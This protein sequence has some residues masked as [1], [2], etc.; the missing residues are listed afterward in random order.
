MNE[1][2]IDT[3]PPDPM[4]IPVLLAEAATR[5]PDACAL[6][7][8]GREPLCYGRLFA[9][10]QSAIDVLNGAGIGP[11]DRVALVLPN[12]PEMVVA[13]LGISACASCA[14]LNPAYREAEFRFYLDDLQAKA[15]VLP[16]HGMPEARAAAAASGVPVIELDPKPDAEAGALTLHAPTTGKPRGRATAC[17]EDVALVLH[18]SGTTSRPKIVPLTQL[19]LRLS[20]TNV[21]SS[22][23]LT[24]SDR[25]LNIMPLFHIHGL[26][27][28]L[29]ASLDA[30]ASVA[31]VPPFSADH[32]FG[33]LDA[34][35]PTW[36]SAVPPMHQAILARADT[37]TETIARRPLRFIRS[38]SSAL[39]PQ[40]MER[41]EQ[42]FGVPVIEA[43]GMTEAA[44]QMTSNPLPPRRRKPRSVGLPAGPEIAIMD[45][46]GKLLGPERSGEV[47]I[48]GPTVTHG[49]ENNPAANA[50]AFRN[51]W[52]R[53]G[54]LGELD[55]D[56]YLFLTGR[57][58]ELI[59]RGGEKVSPR[60]VDE[61]LMDH[62]DVIQAVAFGVPHATLGED[63]AAAVVLRP[64]SQVTPQEL[65]EL[66]FERLAD[67]KVPSRIVVLDEIPKGATGKLQRIGLAEKLASRLEE[68]FVAPR[69][70]LETLVAQMIEEVLRRDRVGI[71]DNF[72]AIG[73]DSLSGTRLMARIRAALGV[74]LPIVTL[75]RKP[76]VEE[77]AAELGKHVDDTQSAELLALLEE[78]EALSDEE[79]AAL[80]ALETDRDAA[81]RQGGE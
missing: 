48:R 34:L 63:L 36:F 54:D 3:L 59:N 44:H 5:H 14:P 13:F 8:P 73:G 41:L 42:T 39:P 15:V 80:L 64:G 45:E 20:A 78:I 66:C 61:A 12:G 19:N 23:A 40:V 9:E 21:A 50:D 47:V 4:T 35:R 32:F 29:L 38:S 28:G 17:A 56:G 51:G 24:R 62:P 30:G 65:R 25:C 18:T 77:F 74:D 67:F 68:G 71:H 27:A 79:A 58:K 76:T 2:H 16:R 43:Y 55:A 26:V 31:C 57:L 37:A 52:F 81:V 1:S 22:L 6:V 11:G 33:W 53:T 60:E 46:N 70:P 69:D 7:A 10:V 49:Y 75:F 72:F